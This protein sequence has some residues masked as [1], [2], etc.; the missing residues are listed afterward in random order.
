MRRESDRSGGVEVWR[1]WDQAMQCLADEE[2]RQ[3]VRSLREVEYDDWRTLPEAAV[4]PNL[5]QDLDELEVRLRHKHL[6][7]LA[8]RGYVRWG[9][10]PLQVRQGPRFREVGSLMGLVGSH[11]DSVADTLV[12]GCRVLGES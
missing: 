10:D 1:R 11:T 7:R 5:Q 9:D 12:D 3:V 6:P 2:R 8:Q 4:S